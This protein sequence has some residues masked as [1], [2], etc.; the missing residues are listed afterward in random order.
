VP[1]HVPTTWTGTVLL[2]ALYALSQNC[3]ERI[4]AS[5]G[6]SVCPSVCPHG[7]TRL[8]WT[9][10]Y[11]ILYFRIFRKSAEK[12]Q[13][14]LKS[15]KNNR[16]FTWTLIYIFDHIS[17]NSS[18]NKKWEYSKPVH[19]LFIDFKKAYDSVRREVL[20]KTLFE[21]GIPRKLV[22]LIKMSLTE[23]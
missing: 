12:I 19:Q 10:F 23:I 13:V 16:Y 18:Y 1:L 5:W 15:D 4:L 8:H 22:R 6:G 20:Y 9:D 3:E 11:E 21:F 17:L 2:L 7:T 14:S